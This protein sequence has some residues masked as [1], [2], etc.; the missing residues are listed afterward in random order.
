MLALVGSLSACSAPAPA[1]AP[2][3]VRAAE[4]GRT[5][6]VLPVTAVPALR[7]EPEPA[8]RDPFD[9]LPFTIPLPTALACRLN[10]SS[11][12]PQSVVLG[13]SRSGPG[14]GIVR[15]RSL[16]VRSGVG[17]PELIVD[18]DA[19]GLLLRA[20]AVGDSPSL[21]AGVSMLFNGFLMPRPA[22]PL[23]LLRGVEEG[24]QVSLSLPPQIVIAGTRSLEARL[25][26]GSLSLQP[27]S[28]DSAALTGTPIGTA[29]L[30]GDA[31]PIAQ[32]PTERPV[33]TLRPAKTDREVSVLAHEKDQTRISWTLDGVVAIG[34]VPKTSLRA[35]PLDDERF[36]LGGF[37]LSGMGPG[38]R[39]SFRCAV[40]VPLRAQVGERTEIVGVILSGTII[41]LDGERMYAYEVD[42]PSTRLEKLEKAVLLV[43][44]EQMVSCVEQ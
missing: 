35:L 32:S 30:R 42:L 44:K 36:G 10:D 18:A 29:Y 6:V 1:G 13:L 31:I 2:A 15:P 26:C 17:A 14:F 20:V 4:T 8:S 33:A 11:L 16:T 24:L 37:G 40:D 34:W 39:R 27:S 22:Q 41:E 43:D 7:A 25:G 5:A 28:F 19:N 3:P 9:G 23:L 21:F 38:S 12:P